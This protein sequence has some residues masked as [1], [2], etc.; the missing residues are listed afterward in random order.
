MHAIGDVEAVR[1]VDGQASGVIE[2]LRRVGRG[3]REGVAGVALTAD[4][5]AGDGGYVA[6]G[7]NAAN[8]VV[9]SV[10][11]VLITG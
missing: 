7:V 5:E 3:V 9:L 4:S 6:G 11:D 2:T 10:G 1:T 8:A